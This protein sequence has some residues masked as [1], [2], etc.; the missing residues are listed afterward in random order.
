MAEPWI[1]LAV[2]DRGSDFW[3]LY[4][5]HITTGINERWYVSPT[6][7]YEDADGTGVLAN[8]ADLALIELPFSALESFGQAQSRCPGSP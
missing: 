8:W 4:L 6:I 3:S 1:I 5:G 7:L 2:I